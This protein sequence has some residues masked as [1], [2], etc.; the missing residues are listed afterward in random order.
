MNRR[1]FLSRLAA[2]PLLAAAPGL[3]GCSKERSLAVSIHPW[4]GYETL[5]LAREFGWLPASVALLEGRTA[6]DSIAALRSGQADAACLTLDETLR[7]RGE[8][9]PL[10][11]GLVFDV[12]VGADAVLARPGIERPADLAGKRLGFE[13][14]A[15]GAL[16]LSKLLDAAGLT[17]AA[18]TL[19]DLPLDRQLSAWREGKVDA[20]ISYEPTAT[21]AQREGARPLFDSRQM[22]ESIFDVLAVHRDRAESRGA[23]L[24]AL[25]ASHFRAQGHLRTHRE[26]ALYRIAAHQGIT[27]DEARLALAGVALPS[28]E[29]NRSYL[30]AGDPRL[31][32]AARAL[33][34]LM[35]RD[36]WLAQADGLGGLTAPDWL[37]VES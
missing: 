13:R 23:A 7:A 16:V 34:A 27:L 25:L 30:S 35:V 20:L 4:I 6:G 5:Y 14:N 24:R 2:L 22:P 19:V 10:A 17:T 33:S 9:L 32:Q 1:R 15:V 3:P 21:L 11:V 31:S 12:S 8:G 37:P 36:G 28:L 29:A 18:L 26:D